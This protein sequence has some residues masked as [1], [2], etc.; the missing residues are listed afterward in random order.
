MDNRS[1]SKCSQ[2]FRFSHSVQPLDCGKC[3][4]EPNI[5]FAGDLGG[6]L[7]LLIGGSALTLLEILDLVFYNALLKVIGR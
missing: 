6:Y 7:G 2:K 5:M 1:F 4:L 3:R